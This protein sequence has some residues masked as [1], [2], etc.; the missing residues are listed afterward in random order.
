MEGSL[1]LIKKFMIKEKTLKA[2]AIILSNNDKKNIALL[3]RG[4]QNDWS[5][6]KGHVDAGEN[7]IQ[8]MIREIKEETGLTV[9]IIEILPDLEYTSSSGEIVSTKM[10]IV[11]S[12]DDSKLKPEFEQDDI[13][14][15]PYNEVIE[16]LSYDNLKDYFFSVSS[17]V[18]KTIDSE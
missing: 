8:T 9:S 5:F 11:L 12:G 18:S 13:Q 2:G 7:S 14:W 6:P 17:T 4:K 15:I 16:K 10:F 1:F 3:Y